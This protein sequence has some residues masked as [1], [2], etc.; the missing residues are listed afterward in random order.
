MKMMR[1]ENKRYTKVLSCSRSILDGKS[2][3]RWRTNKEKK[4]L[5]DTRVLDT[6]LDISEGFGAIP[7]Y[8]LLIN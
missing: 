6:I 5:E 3:K 2:K 8:K 7:A 4:S 1:I